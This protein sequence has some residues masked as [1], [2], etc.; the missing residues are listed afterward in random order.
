MKQGLLAVV[1][2]IASL[3]AVG[4]VNVERTLDGKK[5]SNL[6]LP[7][8]QIVRVSL[9]TFGAGDKLAVIIQAE[10]AVY[11]DITACLF[12]SEAQAMSYKA[13]MGCSNGVQK[14]HMPI[15]LGTEFKENS[16]AYLVLDNS[17]ANVITKKLTY[18]TVFQKQLSDSDVAKLK[19]PLEK[20]HNKISKTFKNSDF[21]LSLKHCGQQN[22]FSEIKNANITVCQELYMDLVAKQNIGA[23][24]GIILHEYGHSLLN[25]WGEPGSSEEDMADQFAAALLLKDGDSGRQLL[26]QWVEFWKQ[27]DSTAEAN[28]ALRNGDAHSLSIQRARNLTNIALYPEDFLR[29]WNKMFYRHM[30]IEEL[31]RVIA[32]PS[33]TDDVDLAKQARASQ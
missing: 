9:G 8:K 2:A 13:E 5:V 4:A 19:T 17:F 27:R 7:P 26:M 15:Q 10:N 3:G 30:T 11:K 6:S 25:R 29:R 20:I 23:L 32:K 28:H 22:A 14:G 24:V 33:K 12:T 18:V 21:D 31:D 16:S 1:L